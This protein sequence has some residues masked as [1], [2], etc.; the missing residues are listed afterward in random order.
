MHFAM[1]QKKNLKDIQYSDLLHTT[2]DHVERFKH[3]RDWR[4]YERE[5]SAVVCRGILICL[6]SENTTELIEIV[7]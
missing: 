3:S 4:E 6:A 7:Y 5:K 1:R 2:T